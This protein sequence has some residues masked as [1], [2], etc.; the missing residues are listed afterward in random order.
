MLGTS[1]RR[2]V[3]TH[4]ARSARSFHVQSV[5]PQWA[6]ARANPA[7]VAEQAL[8]KA[9]ELQSV[10]AQLSSGERPAFT[11]YDELQSALTRL[12]DELDMSTSVLAH[13]NATCNSD[14]VTAEYERARE[15]S[16][17]AATALGQHEELMKTLSQWLED[18][19]DAERE[20]TPAE[21][22]AVKALLLAARQAG[23]GLPEAEKAAVAALRQG[24]AGLSTTFSNNTISSTKEWSLVLDDAR[25]LDGA[26]DSL[27][28]QM[29]TDDGSWKVAAH[30]ALARQLL[31]QLHNRELRQ[32]V[33]TASITRAS[34]LARVPVPSSWGLH[35]TAPEPLVAEAEAPAPHD[36]GPILS[37]ILGG[38]QALATALGYESYAH[39]ST[40]R[41]MTGKPSVV[42]DMLAMLHGKSHTA[43]Q[44]DMRKLTEFAHSRGFPADESLQAWDVLYWSRQYAMHHFDLDEEAVRQYLPLQPVLEDVFALLTRLFGVDIKPVQVTTQ[45]GDVS[46]VSVWDPEVRF[47]MVHDA[48]SQKPLAGFYLDPIARPGEKRAGAWV[49]VVTQR[50][51]SAVLAEGLQDSPVDGVNLVVDGERLPVAHVVLNAP[52]PGK[53]QPT[54]LGFSD[55]VTLLHE[56]GHG[57][58]HMLTRQSDVRVAGIAGIEWDA[59]EVP[60]QWMEGWAYQAGVLRFLPGDVLA[61]LKA[62]K[63]HMAGYASLRQV[64]FGQLDMD[65]HL[66]SGGGAPDPADTA[67]WSAGFDPL[68][69]QQGVAKAHTVV[70]HLPHDRFL[71]QFGHI[72]GGGYAAGYYSYKW[73]EVM[74]AHAFHVLEEAAEGASFTPPLPEVPQLKDNLYTVLKQE[75]GHGP[76]SEVLRRFRDTVLAQGGGQHPAEVFKAFAGQDPDPQHLLKELQQVEPRA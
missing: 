50:A 76:V 65:L 69:L 75:G 63:N 1:V 58:Q 25:D 18:G 6:A 3:V 4:S 31:T 60:S 28:Q 23:I 9:S 33:H 47:F 26:S 48:E 57:L 36:N 15:A 43:A 7:L 16:T 35:S 72:F 64:Y 51:N 41:K 68:L 34:E 44:E 45:P 21:L 42:L 56:L 20:L 59:V 46:A 11:T 24:L 17:A 70:P 8:A 55:V 67:T 30:P 5:L 19:A 10:L 29:A 22:R 66:A 62:A 40:D 49:S 13:L 39:V 53:D 14:A 52:A 54:L 37:R 2:A 32:I 74:A 38:R 71:C 12:E 27:L 73:A 61:K